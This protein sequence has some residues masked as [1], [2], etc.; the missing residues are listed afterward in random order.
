MA[1]PATEQHVPAERTRARA[2]PARALARP[3]RLLTARRAITVGVVAIAFGTL[4]NPES[5]RRTA[6]IQSPGWNRDG[7]MALTLPLVNASDALRIDVPRP[8]F[9][10]AA[11][12][13]EHGSTT[14]GV[15]P[16]ATTPGPHQPQA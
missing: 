13:E 1:T 4:L 5:V 14:E 12:R 16:Y 7:G 2:R 9:P 8:E 11:A 3:R 10:R 15:V 6:E